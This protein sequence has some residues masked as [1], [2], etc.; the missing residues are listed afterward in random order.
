M[1]THPDRPT[2]ADAVLA[3]FAHLRLDNSD[4]TPEQSAAEITAWLGDRDN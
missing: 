3:D 1:N 2:P 4:L